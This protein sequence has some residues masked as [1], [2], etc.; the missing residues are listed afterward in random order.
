MRSEYMGKLIL[1]EASLPGL[2]KRET[3]GTHILEG[4]GR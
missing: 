3:W 1:T 4:S 2:Q